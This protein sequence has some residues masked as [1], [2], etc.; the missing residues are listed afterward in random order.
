MVPD[1]NPEE[2]EEN[3]DGKIILIN[4]RFIKL[5][6]KLTEKKVIANTIL[7][8]KNRSVGVLPADDIN[9]HFHSQSHFESHN[10][11]VEYLILRRNKVSKTEEGI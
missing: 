3:E 11:S 6:P 5:V 9:N 2:V 1:A 8:L 7:E 10:V 4:P